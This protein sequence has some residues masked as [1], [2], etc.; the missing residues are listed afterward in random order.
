[1]QGQVE[2]MGLN[3]MELLILLSPRWA[4]WGKRDRKGKDGAPWSREV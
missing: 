3:E 2:G 4:L 1:M